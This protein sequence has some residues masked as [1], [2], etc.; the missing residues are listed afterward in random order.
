[1]ADNFLQF[2]SS[3]PM[4]TNEERTWTEEHL[5]L[6]GYDAPQ[7]GDARYDEFS[8]FIGIYELEDDDDTLGFDW[9]F[10]R[11]ERG[12]YLWIYAEL[13]GNPNHVAAFVQMFLWK[14]PPN[15][16]FTMSW[17]TT[18]TP[19]HLDELGG[20]AIFVTAKKIEWMNTLT[21]CDEM[22]KRFRERKTT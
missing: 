20:G 6:F 11:G 8:E 19:L 12:E 16:A 9:E 7:E 1:M 18:T 2:G 13:N 17:A 14:F 10:Q 5:E 22:Q 3:I 21:W 4:L 15:G